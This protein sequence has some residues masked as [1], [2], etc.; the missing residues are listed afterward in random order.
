MKRPR[1]E[2]RIRRRGAKSQAK[3]QNVSLAEGRHAMS[4][5]PL[6]MAFDEAA[7]AEDA[8]DEQPPMGEASAASVLANVQYRAPAKRPMLLLQMAPQLLRSRPQIP[9]SRPRKRRRRKKHQTL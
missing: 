2:V 8:D 1:C 3:G 5:A 4:W 7:P 9:S 6:P